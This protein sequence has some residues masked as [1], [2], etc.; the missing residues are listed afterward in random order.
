MAKAKLYR[1]E[2]QHPDHYTV[3][4]IASSEASA[5]LEASHLWEV[6][7]WGRLILDAKVIK[8]GPYTPPV[9]PWA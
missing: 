3:N 7:D 2:V 6:A 8:L 1:Y 9:N 5:V 4:V